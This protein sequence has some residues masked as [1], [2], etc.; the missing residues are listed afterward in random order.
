VGFA[1]FSHFR[2]HFIR[3]QRSGESAPRVC[4]AG[5]G[6]FALVLF[7]PGAGGGPP[8]SY[9]VGARAGAANCA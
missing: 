9:G 1:A 7:V 6:L 3:W 8:L 2:L 4:R 5:D